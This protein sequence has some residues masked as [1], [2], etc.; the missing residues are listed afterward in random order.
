[1]KAVF[2]MDFDCG[3]MGELTGVFVADKDAIKWLIE[4]KGEIYF[5]EVLG[6]HSEIYGPI[7]EADIKLVS[8]APEVVAV[9]EKHELSSGYNPLNYSFL[10]Q[11]DFKDDLG[12]KFE[13]DLSALEVYSL[14]HP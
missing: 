3:R 11:E 9:I 13:Y 10:N 7:D 6:K 12:E 4:N 8:D 14:L 5:G 1:M 2:K